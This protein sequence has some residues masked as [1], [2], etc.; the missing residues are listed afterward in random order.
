MFLFPL[1]THPEGGLLSRKVA[2]FFFSLNIFC[3]VLFSTAAAATPGQRQELWPAEPSQ[4]PLWFESPRGAVATAVC[5]PALDC[6]PAKL[7]L[8][9]ILKAQSGRLCSRHP[10]TFIRVDWETL[11][12]Q[13]RPPLPP[14][15]YLCPSCGKPQLSATAP[16]AD[17]CSIIYH[18]LH[19][20][21]CCT[22]LWFMLC[23]SSRPEWIINSAVIFQMTT[24][25]LF[26]VIFHVFCIRHGA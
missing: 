11:S 19:V 24:N 23:R 20:S 7:L 17:R 1:A 25:I 3:S 18:F 16:S 9:G 4:A 22:F 26:A 13:K 14:A 8:A 15:V 2:L 12:R 21:I 10:P 5:A 6:S